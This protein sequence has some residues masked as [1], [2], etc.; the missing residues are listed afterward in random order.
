LGEA[1][2]RG[3][4][5]IGC[6]DHAEDYLSLVTGVAPARTDAVNVIG[7]PVAIEE[8]ERVR[9]VV[10]SCVARACGAGQAAAMASVTEIRRIRGQRGSVPTF[11]AFRATPMAFESDGRI[12]CAEEQSSGHVRRLFSESF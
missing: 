12:T 10:A 7:V 2:E 6:R 5:A 9:V 8:D 1:E 3:I 4:F 11:W